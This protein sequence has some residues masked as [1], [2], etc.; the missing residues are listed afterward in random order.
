L[1]VGNKEIDE[2]TGKEI[3]KYSVKSAL[4]EKDGK[5]IGLQLELSDIYIHQN[6]DAEKG[7]IPGNVQLKATININ[8]FDAAS[9]YNTAMA[10]VGSYFVTLEVNGKEVKTKEDFFIYGDTGTYTAPS[11]EVSYNVKPEDYKW[12]SGLRYDTAAKMKVLVSGIKNTQPQVTK[13]LNRLNLTLH[14]NEPKESKTYTTIDTIINKSNTSLSVED[15]VTNT[16]TNAA[17]FN[18]ENT[19]DVTTSTDVGKFNKGVTAKL[20][21]RDGSILSNVSAYYADTPDSWLWEHS[22]KEKESSST[23]IFDSDGSGEWLR[24]LGAWDITKKA[25]MPIEDHKTFD[26]T[27]KN[28]LNDTTSEYGN[29]L[30]VQGG[31]LKH[32][33]KDITNT[34]KNTEN[35]IKERCF[36]RRIQFPNKDGQTGVNQ[37]TNKIGIKIEEFNSNDFNKSNAN[38]NVYLA[39]TSSTRVMHLNAVRNL[40][41]EIDPVAAVADPNTY[42]TTTSGS[43]SFGTWTIEGKGLNDEA[44]FTIYTLTDYYLIVTMKKDSTKLGTITLTR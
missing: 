35:E 15:D 30:L 40:T 23:I 33:S 36:V 34:Y 27:T 19:T 5:K 1:F 21:G 13:T 42:T 43:R 14:N 8:T 20:Y 17:V 25:L 3:T 26:S 38:T 6:E 37:I 29:E 39:S 18:Y 4:V 31:W 22:S 10:E 24:T 9:G 2:T 44:V 41:T 28:C 16:L 12:V 7:W 32:P 11:I